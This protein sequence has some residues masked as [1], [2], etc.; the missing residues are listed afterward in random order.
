MKSVRVYLLIDWPESGNLLI[1]NKHVINCVWLILY[2]YICRPVNRQCN[3]G[4]PAKLLW[5]SQAWKSWVLSTSSMG[6][7]MNIMRYVVSSS[8]H[9][10][11]HISLLINYFHGWSCL[12][13]WFT[14]H[15]VCAAG[16]YQGSGARNVVTGDEDCMGRSLWSVGCCYQICNEAFFLDFL[17]LYIYICMH[18]LFPDQGNWVWNN[19]LFKWY[20]KLLRSLL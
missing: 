4:K 12:C 1:K 19:L 13:K 8:I 14:G 15:K 11:A 7:S 2:M 20:C 10:V 9:A 6:W 16:N 18:N 3:S 5:E 17:N